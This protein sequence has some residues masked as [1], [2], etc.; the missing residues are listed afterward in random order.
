MRRSR[1]KAAL[2]TTAKPNSGTSCRCVLVRA[3]SRTFSTLLSHSFASYDNLYHSSALP[4]GGIFVLSTRLR[5][6][7]PV[8]PLRTVLW[9]RQKSKNVACRT[10][11]PATTICTTL[12]LCRRVVFFLWL[13]RAFV[14]ARLL[15]HFAPFFGFVKSQ[16]MLLS[17]SFAG[18]DNLYHSSALPQGGIFCL[19][20]L[21][22]LFDV[23]NFGCYWLIIISGIVFDKCQNLLYSCHFA[24]MSC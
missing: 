11:L 21:F 7:S 13:V 16:R 12:R 9:F 19:I 20:V 17:H 15:C 23:F 4:Q 10:H 6:C 14:L 22:S 18:Y 1:A 3:K 5:A 24:I 2:L 8:V